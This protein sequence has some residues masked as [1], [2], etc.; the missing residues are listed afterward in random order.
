MGLAPLL[1]EQIFEIIQD[2]NNRGTSICWWSKTLKWLFPLPTAVIVL[3]TG[4][5]ILEDFADALW[6]T[7]R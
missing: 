6:R 4:K 2:I 3:E 5:I 7:R 1:V